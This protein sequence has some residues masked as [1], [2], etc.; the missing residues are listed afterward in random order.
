MWVCVR[1]CVCVCVRMCVCVRKAK[2]VCRPDATPSSGTSYVSYGKVCPEFFV[3]C[4][5]MH[6]RVRVNRHVCSDG[7]PNTPHT[8]HLCSD[9]VFVKRHTWPQ[10]WRVKF[11]HCNGS[12]SRPPRK[13]PVL[14][15]WFLLCRKKAHESVAKKPI[16]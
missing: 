12:I 13:H 4:A 11:Q 10:S 6:M 5:E 16:S 15:H 2:P 9:A 3:S 14:N 1:V 7:H 8:T